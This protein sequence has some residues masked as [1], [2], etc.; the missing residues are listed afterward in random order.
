MANAGQGRPLAPDTEQA[1]TIFYSSASFSGSEEE[2]E[3]N[4]FAASVMGLYI[5]RRNLGTVRQAEQ[6]LYDQLEGRYVGAA[7][8]AWEIKL[9]E[10]ELMG[11]AATTDGET[12]GWVDATLW[13]K[14]H[15]AQYGSTTSS[16]EARHN[17]FQA[18]A[19]AFPADLTHVGHDGEHTLTKWLTK[20]KKASWEDI[21]NR[22]IK[23]FIL[24]TTIPEDVRSK[25]G[26]T[27]KSS[28]EEIFLML[29]T[30]PHSESLAEINRY[31]D[32]TQR[33]ESMRIGY[34]EQ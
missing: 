9:A 20:M 2:K 3:A 26:I 18:R 15:V 32:L 11:K 24:F 19:R 14:W 23:A 13:R 27:N 25:V 21:T 30:L 10:L 1:I 12:R 8:T 16:E 22:D 5:N 4:D 6:T 28:V 31:H 34:P 7:A 33:V 29:N 17:E